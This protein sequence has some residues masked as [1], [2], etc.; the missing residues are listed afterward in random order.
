ME[1][2]M[3]SHLTPPC[4][5]NDTP[6]MT[7][8]EYSVAYD[9]GYS[10]TVAFI[11]SRGASRDT[12]EDLAQ[13][14]WA[15]G[16]QYREQIR[17]PSKV[18]AWVNTIAFNLFRGS[19]R[20]APTVELH[21]GDYPSLPRNVAETIDCQRLFARCSPSERK[22]INGNLAGYTSAELGPRLGLSA[23]AVRVRLLRLRRRLHGTMRPKAPIVLGAR[24]NTA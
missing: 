8:E 24:S 22:L 2:P 21:P 19:F 12:S 11:L 20:K 15:K 14:A 7:R 23:V 1:E 17:D 6:I 10:K 9:R 3:T 13:A 4:K 16:W 5:A 18:D